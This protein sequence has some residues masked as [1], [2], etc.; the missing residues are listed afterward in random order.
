MKKLYTTFFAAVLFISVQAQAPFY[1]WGEQAGASGNDEGYAIAVDAAGNSYITGGF[2]DTARFGSFTL[3]NAGPN[4]KQTFVA[5]Y[6]AS[7]TC[8]WAKQ[9]GCPQDDQGQG[10]CV[11]NQ[12]NVYITGYYN[13][14][15]ATFGSQ[16]L[17]AAA[18][19]DI[20]IVKYD[21][22]GNVIWATSEG[23]GNNDYGYSLA[24]DG[25]NNLFLTGNF[26]GTSTFGTTGLSSSGWGDIY[27]AKYNATTGANVWA[28]KAGASGDDCSYSIATDGGGNTFITG[29]FKGT[30]TFGSAGSVTSSG[31]KDI[32]TAKLDA[33]GAFVWVKKGG[34]SLDDEGRAITVDGVGAVNVT[35][36]YD[37]AAT[38]GTTNLTAVGVM[39]VFTARYDNAANLQWA[40]SHGGWGN[41]KGMGMCIDAQ[42]YIYI[43]GPFEQTVT[44]GSTNLPTTGII[45]AFVAKINYATG[46]AMWALKGG[47]EDADEAYGIGI[48]ANAKLY[49]TG[50]FQNDASFGPL[51]I[52]NPLNEVF[53][54][55]L[56]NTLSVNDN[57]LNP[58]TVVLFP[59]PANTS[60][61]ITL[62]EAVNDYIKSIKIM[63]LSGR[64]VKEIENLNTLQTSITITDLAAGIYQIQVISGQ[65]QATLKGIKQ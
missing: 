50:Y 3:I 56:D 59:N 37:N 22:N 57:F 15:A 13:Y 39:D 12:G 33:N 4:Y 51:L 16:N 11:D 55:K 27:V 24:I 31:G 30:T 52:A 23:G 47:G 42:G 53:L 34:G 21:A 36:Y 6:N 58:I 32:F 9:G 25:N 8:L 18:W 26:Y 63:D 19:D 49:F 48:D 40:T 5:K 45:D 54:A 29:C 62:T 2:G 44:F 46:A 60:W 41:D 20:F 28:V 38:F 10:I 17:P 7:G 14:S 1:A 64:C 43:T 61:N 65:G 35:G